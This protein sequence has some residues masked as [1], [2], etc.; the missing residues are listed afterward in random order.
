MKH[1]LSVT[2]ALIGIFIVSQLAGLYLIGQ[3]IQEFSCDED[4]G[5]VPV[6]TTTTVGERPETR[7]AGS[8]VYLLVGIG[9]GTAL[10]LL[11]AKFKKTNV[12]RAWFFF[13]VV[14]ATSVALGVLLPFGV[15]WLIAIALAAWKLWRPNVI[16]Y[17]LSEVLMYAGIAVL[18]API[19]DVF[20]M[21]ILLIIISAYDAY[22]VWKSKHMVRMA[23]F[24]TKSN[25][26]AGLVV[27]YRVKGGRKGV[28]M[29]LPRSSDGSSLRGEATHKSA[30]LGGGDIT[31]PLLF[32]GVV[33]QER[34]S[35]LMSAGV[36]FEA[37]LWQSFG[38]SLFIAAGATIA[39][40]GLFLFAKKDTF[41]PAMPFITA[42]CLVGWAF[43]LLL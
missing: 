20:W 9:I 6:H 24:I 25:A 27:P 34:F 7:G 40:A 1:E 13:A 43:T 2:L 5:C 37:A 16:I 29:R 18:I 28:T 36:A 22:A 33:L 8:M 17:N 35:T 14:M 21:I 15:A 41:Y 39:V 30:I 10:L 42:G 38:A 26:F 11:I 32:G 3:S 19:L 4:D 31:F 23:Q 12:W